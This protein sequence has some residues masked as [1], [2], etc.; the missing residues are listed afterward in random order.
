MVFDFH[1]NQHVGADA[2]APLQCR[3][4]AAGGLDVVFLDQ[5]GVEQTDA[6][7]DAA[8]AGHRVF[9]RQPQTRQWFCG[10]PAPLWPVPAT[11]ST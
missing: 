5:N 2:R 11:A 10:C 9:L 3:R 6:M 1:F 4:D 7:I 8:A